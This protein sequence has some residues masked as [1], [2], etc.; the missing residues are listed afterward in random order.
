[1][2]G[3]RSSTRKHGD[4]DNAVKYLGETDSEATLTGLQA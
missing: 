3:H 4:K 1:M 2:P